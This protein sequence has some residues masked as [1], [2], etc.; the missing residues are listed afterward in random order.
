MR[1]V[2]SLVILLLTISVTAGTQLNT[3]ALANETDFR[4]TFN[5][6]LHEFDKTESPPFSES[7]GFSNSIV[8]VIQVQCDIQIGEFGDSNLRVYFRFPGEDQLWF[9]YWWGDAGHGWR[10]LAKAYVDYEVEHTSVEMDS[11]IG[12]RMTSISVT[13]G[14]HHPTV[15][16]GAFNTGI[17]LLAW[18]SSASVSVGECRWSVVFEGQTSAVRLEYLP[19]AIVAVA[20]V[21]GGYLVI[22]VKSKG[23]SASKALPQ[24]QREGKPGLLLCPN[25]GYRNPT[26]NRFCARCGQPISD[27]TKIY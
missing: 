11:P 5:T 3:P 7:T 27:E 12:E 4:Y 16:G 24:R 9:E 26:V 15:D 8:D 14:G 18:G 13:M 17:G 19:Y 23:A 25:C 21:L 2:L 6:V 10:G 20:T 1:S 22:R